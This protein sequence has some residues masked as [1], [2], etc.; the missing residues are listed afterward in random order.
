MKLNFDSR[1]SMRSF[2]LA[3]PRFTRKN[4]DSSVFSGVCVCVC[5]GGDLND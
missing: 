3:N 4:F 5:G 1:R 2:I